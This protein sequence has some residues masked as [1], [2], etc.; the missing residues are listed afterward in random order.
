MPDSLITLEVRWFCSGTPPLAV[1]RW[2]NSC[3]GESLRA[4]AER[5]DLYLYAPQCE[6]LNLKL[7][8]GK[9][10]LKWR[11]EALG[12]WQFADLTGKL[13]R[14]QKWSCE[15]SR[16][17]LPPGAEAG[18][19]EVKK[20]RSQRQDQG[21]VG[22]LT[23]LAVQE[24]HWWSLAFEGDGSAYRIDG[25]QKV[26]SRWLQSYPEPKL[27]T[28]HSCAYPQWLTWQNSVFPPTDR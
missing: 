17:M 25:F 8:Q 10:E 15:D 28:D 23:Q 20:V 2:F 16:Q 24:R 19:I 18:W 13:E 4:S 11:L 21:V 27:T 5:I 6:Y 12:D 22:E 3:S 26:L 1:E 7:R 9:L 14:W